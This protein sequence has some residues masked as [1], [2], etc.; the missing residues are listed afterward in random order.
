MGLF[1][2]QEN[3][4]IAVILAAGKGTRIKEADKPK[5]YLNIGGKPMLCYTV[6]K[7]LASKQI[8]HIVVAVC[9]GWVQY[10]QDL[11]TG[12]QY[13]HISVCEGADNRQESLYK[14]LIY[15]QEQLNASDDTV[16]ISHDAARPFVTQEILDANVHAIQMAQSVTTVIPAV[17]TILCSRDGLMMASSTDR[18]QMYQVQT[19]QTFRLRQYID[20]YQTL[21][22]L[23]I[24]QLTDVSGMFH[25]YGIPVILVQ[26]DRQN[27][28]ITTNE[29]LQYAEFLIKR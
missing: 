20:V 27:I 18:K 5:Q 29:D 21:D 2:F 25:G 3:M 11:F 9:K 26:G 23:Q 4:N 16:I 24:S 8:S 7:F 13:S 10:T 19:P 6:E 15:C 14:A 12:M 17:D 1:G 28:K 22:N